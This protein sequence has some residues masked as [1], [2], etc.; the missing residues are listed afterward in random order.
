QISEKI[1]KNVLINSNDFG[2]SWDEI[3]V[4]LPYNMSSDVS[5][6]VFYDNNQIYFSIKG[7]NIDINKIYRYNLQLN[8]I[9]SLQVDPISNNDLRKAFFIYNR[10]LFYVDVDSRYLFEMSTEGL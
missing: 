8:V 9:D 2:C 5:M 6:N 10:K 7:N 3:N 1:Y 4:E